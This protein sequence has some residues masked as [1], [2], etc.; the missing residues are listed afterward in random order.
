[1]IPAVYAIAVDL[2]GSGLTGRVLGTDMVSLVGVRL[3]QST[4]VDTA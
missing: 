1:M 2:E 3:S 4:G